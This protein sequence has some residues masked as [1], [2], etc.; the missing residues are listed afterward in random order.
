M[1]S[2]SLTVLRLVLA[3]VLAT[4]I[5]IV[6]GAVA[7]SFWDTVHRKQRGISDYD[8]YLVQVDGTPIIRTTSFGQRTIRDLQGRPLPERSYLTAE[9]LPGPTQLENYSLSTDWRYR[10]TAWSDG[11]TPPGRWYFIH[12]G[13]RNGRAWFEGYD[14]VTSKRIGFIGRS[15]FTVARPAPD[16]AFP[17]D[18]RLRNAAGPSVP[19]FVYAS[20][21]SLVNTGGSQGSPHRLDRWKSYLVSQG[22]LWEIDL[23]QR[24]VRELFANADLVSAAVIER[25]VSETAALHEAPAQNIVARAVDKLWIID[26]RSGAT[27]QFA[28]TSELRD[29]AFEVYEV[30]GGLLLHTGGRYS[31]QATLSPRY[32]WLDSEGKVTRDS[33]P[34]GNKPDSDSTTPLVAL[35]EGFSIVP[36]PIALGVGVAVI[37]PLLQVDGGRAPNYLSALAGSLWQ[38]KWPILSV[39]V[40]AA[41]IGCWCYRRQR[42]YGQ[43]APMAWFI[44]VFLF[45][46]PG[47]L[48][49]LVHRSW[50]VRETCLACHQLV[51][52]DREA[53]LACGTVFPEPA[54]TGAEVFA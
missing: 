47:L 15:G 49:Y 1:K 12:D 13:R 37:N 42:R 25:A 54:A 21:D 2:H 40:L 45:G 43:P 46:L 23:Q 18:A 30:S 14:P 32:V 9:Y 41:I 19:G 10:V 17:F 33:G 34:L 51:P 27:R 7:G 28:L 39:A 6:W 35:A 5:A 11:Q 16:D 8:E 20:L 44:F 3:F 52:R 22:H 36:I 4:G 50:P 48:A 26:P 53:C 29:T 31:Y 24:A 38:W